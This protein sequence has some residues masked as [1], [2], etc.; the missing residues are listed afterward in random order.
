MFSLKH[1]IYF[2][3]L[4]KHFFHERAEDEASTGAEVLISRR[5]ATRPPSAQAPSDGVTICK[6]Y[7]SAIEV[8]F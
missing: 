8:L 3:T 2:L 6:L 4:S 1:L 7:P 5:Y